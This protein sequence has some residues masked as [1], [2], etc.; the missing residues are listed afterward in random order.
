MPI[1]PR[2]TIKI[3]IPIAKYF[4]GCATIAKG[5]SD[6]A[7]KKVLGEKFNPK[8]AGALRAIAQ[9]F[10]REA[11]RIRIRS[12][13][14]VRDEAK[15]I[16]TACDVLY[17]LLFIGRRDLTEDFGTPDRYIEKHSRK[18]SWIL[19]ENHPPVCCCTQEEFVNRIDRTADLAKQYLSKCPKPKRGRMSNDLLR[20][21]VMK[22]VIPILLKH[23]IKK[24]CFRGSVCF[25]IVQLELQAVGCKIADPT[26]LYT[27]RRK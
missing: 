14:D 11:R 21:F 22:G 16:I 13:A 17:D 24:S 15:A 26:R 25:K 23:G 7:L 2:S 3:R 9:H 12:G 27:S 5:P 6:E 4:T 20:R 10:V 1:S 8:L 19:T 18:G